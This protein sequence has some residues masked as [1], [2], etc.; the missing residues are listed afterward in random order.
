MALREEVAA[1]HEE[2]GTNG[3][4]PS[5][6]RPVDLVH[7]A[8]QTFGNADLER[9]IL[10][11]F[12]RQIRSVRARIGGAGREERRQLAHGLVGAARGVGAFC[13]ASCA[14]DIESGADGPA[15]LERLR[16]LI[17][18]VCDFVTDMDGIETDSLRS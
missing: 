3:A 6:G 8:R 14:A 12:L 13:L 15:A 4:A 10:S 11:M 7:L 1:A 9:E 18:E 5:R 2:I 16:G 17:D